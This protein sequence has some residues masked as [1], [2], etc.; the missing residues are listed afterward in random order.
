[1]KWGVSRNSTKAQHL[2]INICLPNLKVKVLVF[3]FFHDLKSLT[4]STLKKGMTKWGK[5]SKIAW[6]LTVDGVAHAA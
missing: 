1:M 3:F 6:W 2:K 4:I 5:N